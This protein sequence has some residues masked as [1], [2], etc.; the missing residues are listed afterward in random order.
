MKKPSLDETA[1]IL[2]ASRRPNG[3]RPASMQ[4]VGKSHSTSNNNTSHE[5][6][7]NI[8]IRPQ[9]T[10]A[11]LKDNR[12]SVQTHK[13]IFTEDTESL[14]AKK[15]PNALDQRQSVT[16]GNEVINNNNRGDFTLKKN[17]AEIEVDEDGKMKIFAKQVRL[18][19]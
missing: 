16:N 4:T 9:S 15:R 10:S 2:E 14:M 18:G 11:I 12:T 1:A 19:N 7:N 5:Y 3:Q 6:V 8:P 17:D 13:P